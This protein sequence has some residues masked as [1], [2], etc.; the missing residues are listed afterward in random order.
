MKKTTELVSA[1]AI[2]VVSSSAA[3]AQGI[4]LNILVAGTTGGGVSQGQAGGSLT[5]TTRST[6]KIAGAISTLVVSTASS[7]STN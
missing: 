2:V 5:A 3:M 7:T 1:V 6:A 4:P